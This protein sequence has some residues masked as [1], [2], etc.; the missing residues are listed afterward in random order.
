MENKL[1]NQFYR[2]LGVFERCSLYKNGS[3]NVKNFKDTRKMI[4]WY[5][6]N[7]EDAD[8]STI[9]NILREPQ[10]RKHGSD[11]KM[12]KLMSEIFQLL[13][14]K[15][16]NAKKVLEN[17]IKYCG[18]NMDRKEINK[19]ILIVDPNVITSEII[20][21]L[22]PQTK[23]KLCNKLWK[24]NTP[25]E[26]IKIKEDLEKSKLEVAELEGFDLCNNT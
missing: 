20:D 4:R 2:K 15:F 17:I 18:K 8:Y 25:V 11:L 5:V 3:Y 12:R 26:W 21:I 1:V 13:Q 22:H 16:L 10:M 23:A 19:A 9:C 7:A 24:G 14:N 6:K